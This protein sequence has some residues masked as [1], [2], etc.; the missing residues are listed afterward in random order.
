MD[1]SRGD[2]GLFDYVLL[3]WRLFHLRH[4]LIGWRR[5]VHKNRTA[6]VESY[7]TDGAAQTD[8]SSPVPNLLSFTK[9]PNSAGKS[10]NGADQTPMPADMCRSPGSRASNW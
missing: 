8:D 1:K 5:S 4:P 9:R 7:V 10:T 2:R 6:F 3:F